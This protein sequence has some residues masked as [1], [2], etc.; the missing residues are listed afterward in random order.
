MHIDWIVLPYY[1]LRKRELYF[2]LSRHLLLEQPAAFASV[3]SCL[4][5]DV[6]VVICSVPVHRCTVQC[7][8]RDL[9]LSFSFFKMTNSPTVLISFIFQLS[10]LFRYEPRCK[11][12]TSPLNPCLMHTCV[13]DYVRRWSEP[14][15][16]ALLLFQ[17]FMSQYC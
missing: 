13:L 2:H 4:T 12:P 7:S 17:S 1:V 16:F 6:R 15:P 8:C 5:Q 14:S 10:F 3:L 9:T 11:C